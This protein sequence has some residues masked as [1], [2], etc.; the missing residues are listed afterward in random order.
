MKLARASSVVGALVVGLLHAAPARAIPRF[1]ARNGV[2]CVQCHV[3]PTGGG[4]RNEY[5][6]NVFA[7]TWLPWSE[8]DLLPPWGGAP[9]STQG[10][11]ATDSGGASF[12]GAVTDWLR[13]GFDLR[14]AY[15]YIRPDERPAPGQD[16]RVTS[17]FFLMQGDLYHA[18]RAERHLTL[19]LDV[20]VYA[21]FEAWGLFELWPERRDKNV[22]LKVGRFMPAFGIREVEHQLFTRERVGFGSADRDTG[23]ELTALWGP[24]SISLAAVNG[25]LGETSFD[26]A[27]TQREPFEQAL[28][29]RAALGAPVGPLRLQGGLSAYSSQNASQANPLFTGAI[30]SS[31]T[32]GVGQGVDE[33]R[34][35]GFATLNVG[36]FT[37]LGDFV[38]V[39]D[40]FADE[41]VPTFTGYASYQELSFV[42]HQG[43]ELVA[44]LEFMDRDTR[45]ADNAA[46]RAGG[47]VELFPLAST[48]VRLMVRRLWDDASTTGATW[49]AV[50][51]A[52]LF[53]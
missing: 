28:I 24:A 17:S 41:A 10:V 21:G 25:T 50:V 29:A 52:H 42:A 8:T 19:V 40:R 14:A 12:S 44:T 32:A 45:I 46:L 13:L 18:V 6:A 35:G 16:R 34:L 5:G 33:L 26:S 53:Y 43:L 38:R 36:R 9:A 48:E 22:F 30:P 1:A 49:D 7:R 15:I 3:N 39:R 37:Y 31:L 2:E 23:L 4:L 27:G 51:F 20:G 11:D 47:V